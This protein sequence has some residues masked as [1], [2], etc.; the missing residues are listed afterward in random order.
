[1]AGE[2]IKIL[3]IDDRPD[4]IDA[5]L[6]NLT[7]EFG[8]P[9]LQRSAEEARKELLK[10]PYDI[11]ILDYEMIKQGNAEEIL[12]KIREEN[13]HIKVIMVTAKLRNVR[14]L[15]GV[16]N[17]GISK[18]YFKNDDN[19]FKL[20]NDGIR[21]T[22]SSRNSIILGLEKYLSSRSNDDKVIMI[23]G[24]QKLTAKELLTEIKKNSDVG[25]T[26]L[27]SLTLLAIRLM[28]EDQT[29]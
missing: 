26:E 5:I 27:E 13:Y 15:A 14:Q 16:V 22:I 28:N 21:E 1:M 2:Q 3:Y 23:R 7:K 19:L 20:L 11:I 24:N 29:K 6:A 18:C 17:Q 12:A 4:E 9:T 8:Q 25:K 10:N